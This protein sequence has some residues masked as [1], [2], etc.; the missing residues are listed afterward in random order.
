[1]NMSYPIA[2]LLAGILIGGLEGSLWLGA[3][4]GGLIGLALRQ[5]AGLEQRVKYLEGWLHR[6]EPDSR[7]GEKTPEPSERVTE[8]EWPEPEPALASHEAETEEPELAP[9]V[10]VAQTV[11][12]ESDAWPLRK[13]ADSSQ[14]APQRPPP[15]PSFVEQAVSRIAA[16]FTS[17]NVPVKIGVIVTFVGVSFLLKYA[18]DRELIFLPIEFRL[19]GVALFGLAL[20]AIGWRLRDKSAVYALSLQGGGAGVLFLTVF[21]AYRI[22]QLLPSSLTFVLLTALAAI[23]AMLAV[24]QNSRTL[25]ILAISGGF[26]APIFA[27]TGQGSHVA[28]FSYYLVL[29]AAIL[30]IAWF[31]AWRELNLLGFVF[32]FLIG[33]IWGF[34]YY[35]PELWTSTEP[36]LVL[37]FLLYNVIAILFAFRQNPDQVEI[38]DGTLVFGTPTIVFALQA[39]LMEGSEYG[40]AISAVAAAVFYT[41]TAVWLHRTRGVQQRLLTESFTALAVV[42]FTLAIPLALDAR[43][44]SAAWALEGAA[45][46]WVGVRQGRQLAKYAGVLLILASGATFIENGWNP[47]AGPLLLN[48]NVLGGLL[49]SISALFASRKLEFTDDPE[50]ESMQKFALQLLFIW[51]LAWWLGTGF[52]ETAER[53]SKGYEA[54]VYLIF[55]ALSMGVAAWLG[56]ALQWKLLRLCTRLFLPFLL[57]LGLYQSFGYDHLLREL[58]WLAWPAAWATQYFLLWSSDDLDD[59][60]SPGWHFA[61]LMLLTAMLALEASWWVH[62]VASSA[63]AG[64]TVT[65]VAGLVA[66]L[67]WQLRERPAWPVPAYPAVYRN[68]GLVLVMAQVIMLTMLSVNNPGN[69]EPLSY[70]P[71]INPYGLGMLFAGVTSLLSLKAISRQP[72][73][74]S[75][76]LQPYRYFL[77]AAFFI[78]TTV[79][80]V[81]AVHFYT[82]VPWEGD[83]LFRSVVVQTTLSIYWGLL[84]FAGM[85]RGA[86]RQRRPIWLTGAGIMALVVVKL[87]LV[88]LGNTGTLERIISFIGI[89][90]LLLVVGYFAPAPPRKSGNADDS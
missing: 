3:A 11:T 32:T 71:I 77:A 16:W 79:A 21:A 18:I 40:L 43:W 85:I 51:G 70:I 84:G 23:T 69:P 74:A 8:Q 57:L 86:R 82:L 59:P 50:F 41:L 35:T 1:M 36:F 56:K 72:E 76:V 29:N 13:P 89:G 68:G 87:F 54:P 83:A 12:L 63:W 27:S 81:R 39:A 5:I 6:L 62:Q 60:L 48:G 30:G 25:V 53:S 33:S 66:W 65:A 14:G 55:L 78:L 10:P 4:A 24:L 67:T 52:W 44:T 42:F 26:L 58:G 38:V 17:G 34:Q 46:V 20:I 19:L 9:P 49:I 2:G 31:R 64:S 37:H 28:L 73:P 47:E 88:D 75:E 15:G 45:L 80:L 22:W 61:S 90:A 7:P